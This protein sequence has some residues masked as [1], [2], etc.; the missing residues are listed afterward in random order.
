M[1]TLCVSAFAVLA[2]AASAHAQDL[3]I[4]IR[5]GRLLDGVGVAENINP[6]VEGSR[7]T[8]L[9]TTTGPVTYDLSDLTVMPGWI[10]THVHLTNHF[11]ADETPAQTTQFLSLDLNIAR[12]KDMVLAKL[13]WSKLRD[14]ERQLR[15]AAEILS[16]QSSRLD[17]NHIE[18]WVAE[19][20]LGEQWLRA[21]DLAESSP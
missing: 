7:V 1:K 5:A 9:E 18:S 19:L 2:M 8:R 10:D 20:D 17:L 16:I 6:T 21:K 3:P 14:S 12:A 15:D 4:T 13:E 11:D